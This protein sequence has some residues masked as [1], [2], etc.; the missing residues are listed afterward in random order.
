LDTSAVSIP[1]AANAIAAVSPA[2][3]APITAISTREVCDA[4]AG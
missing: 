4:R 2:G 1:A 3:P